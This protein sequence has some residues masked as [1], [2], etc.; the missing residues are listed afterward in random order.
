MK[1]DFNINVADDIDYLNNS[2]FFN[3]NKNV[4]FKIDDYEHLFQN[5]TVIIKLK[6]L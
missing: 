4:L 6:N 5:E 2:D 1:N 3:K